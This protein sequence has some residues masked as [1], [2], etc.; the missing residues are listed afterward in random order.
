MRTALYA[1][2]S[3]DRQS[4]ASIDDQVR[5]CRAAAAREGWKVV[6]V[7]ADYALSGAHA[8][9]RP[10]LQAMLA[11]VETGGLDLVLAESLDRL[12]RDQEHIA[13]IW[14]RCRFHGV[15]IRTVADGLVDELAIGFK[16]T[17]SALYLKDLAAKT[18]RGL[19][20]VVAQGRAAAA[21][22]YGY[23][24]KVIHD[25]AGQVIPGLQEIDEDQA[26]VVRRIFQDYAAGLGPRSIATAL[27]REGVAAPRST[28]WAAN[29]IL[30]DRARGLGLLNNRLYIGERVW[31]RRRWIKDP[32]T[33]RRVPRD[34][35]ESDWV[36]EPAP[37][38]AIVDRALW[39]EVKAL[40]ATA[41]QG[42]RTQGAA[43]KARPRKRP[44]HPFSGLLVCGACGGTVTTQGRDRL[45][46][47]N[48]KERGTCKNR[49]TTSRALV[50][51]RV[52]TALK[53]RL[54]APEL[55]AAFVA[56]YRAERKRLADAARASAAGDRRKLAEIE[57]RLARQLQA[58]E[59]G[60]YSPTLKAKVEDLEAEA[61]ALRTRL[62]SVDDDRNGVV[63]MH[64]AAPERYRRMIE[65]LQA[66]L[67]TADERGRA[68]VGA[69]LRALIDEIRV[70]PG[71]GRGEIML[72]IAGDMAAF[73]A[74]GDAAGD[75]KAGALISKNGRAKSATAECRVGLV[76][77]ARNQLSL[78]FNSK[79]ITG[80]G[81]GF[82]PPVLR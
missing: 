4:E 11:S 27:N 45:G 9:S 82:K 51:R 73:L 70:I 14:K 67:E 21:P 30:G 76:A 1:R 7:Y 68:E 69:T 39:E 35:P 75:T 56:E 55:V 61:A 62:E 33:G 6:E 18:H 15:E 12:A 50:E 5:L 46:C 20:G 29:T 13:A 26:S 63:E 24:R 54:A 79:D 34:N 44:K 80:T 65:D 66:A 31:N 38:L 36:I 41:G 71:Q 43:D 28:A 52:F 32:Q 48:A 40:Q 57:R 49:K 10:Q 58:I 16:G 37:E 22:A 59:D 78:L 47:S 25:A 81:G 17:L 72:E 74:L 2:Y 53:E 19:A 3:S 60:L 42:V 8:A 64:A 77:G 23:R